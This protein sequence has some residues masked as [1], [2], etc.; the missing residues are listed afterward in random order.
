MKVIEK[1]AKKFVA[2]FYYYGKMNVYKE[3]GDN[4]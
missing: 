1:R 4:R 3:R 2:F